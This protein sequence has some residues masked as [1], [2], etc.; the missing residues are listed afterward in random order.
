MVWSPAVARVVIYAGY[1]TSSHPARW[2]DPSINM[3]PSYPVKETHLYDERW[4]TNKSMVV[5]V[6]RGLPYVVL[7]TPA[8][9]LRGCLLACRLPGPPVRGR[10]SREWYP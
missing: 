10:P 2:S 9:V 5:V 3:K 7:R 8:G 1:I 4:T 6:A